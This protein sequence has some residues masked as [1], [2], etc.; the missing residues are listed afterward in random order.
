MLRVY[1]RY[2]EKGE[3]LLKQGQPLEQTASSIKQTMLQLYGFDNLSDCKA[4]FVPARMIPTDH[5]P[6]EY[7]VRVFLMDSQIKKALVKKLAYDESYPAAWK[8]K[9]KNGKHQGKA[10]F[11]LGQRNERRIASKWLFPQTAGHPDFPAVRRTALKAVKALFAS[12]ASFELY[13]I[14]T[15]AIDQTD[16]VK[17]RMLPVIQGGM[18]KLVDTAFFYV[19]KATFSS[20]AT[21]PRKV[22]KRPAFLL[23][24]LKDVLKS[25]A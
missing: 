12:A 19:A 2:V 1:E 16:P 18:Q 22:R 8:E 25:G 14:D 15:R 4:L 13:F 24:Y 5:I 11:D 17:A 10:R 21:C 9:V 6:Q 3:T 23:Q 7:N 20:L